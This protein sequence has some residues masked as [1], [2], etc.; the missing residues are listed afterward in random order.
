MTREEMIKRA[1]EL[2]RRQLEAL[3]DFVD[4]FDVQ[5]AVTFEHKGVTILDPWLKE[6]AQNLIFAMDGHDDKEVVVDPS[7]YYGEEKFNDYVN[8]IITRYG[9]EDLSDERYDLLEEVLWTCR[10]LGTELPE[11]Y[12][13]N[14]T[15]NDMRKWI[16]DLEVLL[17]MLE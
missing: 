3:W 15:N 13:H 4:I 5:E 2:A 11:G 1:E 10:Q 16:D 12:P 7:T 6:D 8:R 17:D 14:M 9:V